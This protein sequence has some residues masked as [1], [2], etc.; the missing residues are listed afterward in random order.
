MY[1]L[2][3]TNVPKVW[4]SDIH[5]YIYADPHN[6]LVT[7]AFISFCLVQFGASY[8]ISDLTNLKKKSHLAFK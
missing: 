8:T 4:Q 1:G 2:Q 5:A 6:D 7:Q 3:C